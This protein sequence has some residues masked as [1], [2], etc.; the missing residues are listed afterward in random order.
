M[1]EWMEWMDGMDG[2]D[3]WMDGWMDGPQMQILC[4]VGIKW[5]QIGFFCFFSFYFKKEKKNNATQCSDWPRNQN[6]MSPTS[7]PNW[8]L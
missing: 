5:T 1:T 6:F 3:G 7:V 2:M 8:L 4:T